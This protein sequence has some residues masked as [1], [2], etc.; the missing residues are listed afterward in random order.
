MLALPAPETAG[1]RRVSDAL[2][3]LHLEKLIALHRRIGSPPTI[4][5]LSATGDG[6]SY[7]RP[8]PR[9][10]SVPLGLWD[11]QWITYLSGSALALLIVLMELQGGKKSPADAPSAS[12]EK[13]ARYGL[14]DDTWTRASRELK[15]LG[16]LTVHRAPQGQDFD[17]RRM[18]NTY[19]VSIDRL[20][21]PPPPLAS[22]DAITK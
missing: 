16:V 18:R 21:S 2:N 20:S 5:L 22:E 12:G 9:W 13:R 14:S 10:V 3:W 15:E 4:K 11:Q 8:G 6:A 1:A 7:S 17:W 19:W